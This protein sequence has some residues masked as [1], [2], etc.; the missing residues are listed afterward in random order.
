VAPLADDGKGTKS[1][2]APLADDG[3]GTKADAAPL[4]DDGKGTKADVAP[5]ADDGKG[6]KAD[7][8][9]LADDGKGTKAD[10]ASL[11]DD[12]KGTKAD[13]A[14]LADDCRGTQPYFDRPKG[15]DYP[16][17]QTVIENNATGEMVPSQPVALTLQNP[18]SAKENIE[19]LKELEVVKAMLSKL[20]GHFHGYQ[21]M[22][23]PVFNELTFANV[24]K[25][26][27]DSDDEDM[28]T[29]AEEFE[30]DVDEGDD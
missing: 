10:V 4:A 1:D 2:G 8:A 13:A 22:P 21:H 20:P 29:M 6:T 9:S 15:E 12:G 24:G 19:N 28:T 23:P 25:K 14:P 17:W 27:S 5:L 18:R 30:P 16:S 26:Y 7:V 3:K 11:A